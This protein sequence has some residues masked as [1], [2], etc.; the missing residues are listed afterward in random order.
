MVIELRR[1]EVFVDVQVQEDPFAGAILRD[2]LDLRLA[3]RRYRTQSDRYALDAELHAIEA[4]GL[5]AD[6]GIAGGRR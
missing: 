5:S 1:D 2:E 3:G 4:D 6:I